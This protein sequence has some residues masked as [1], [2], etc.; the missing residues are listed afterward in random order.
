MTLAL[1]A[2]HHDEMI[3]MWRLSTSEKPKEDANTSCKVCWSL[4]PIFSANSMASHAAMLC[5]PTNN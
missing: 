2:T 1:Y 3:G 5:T 4:I